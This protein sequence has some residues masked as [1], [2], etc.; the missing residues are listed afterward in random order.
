MRWRA[1][2]HLRDQQAVWVPR[3]HD[4][5]SFVLTVKR[6]ATLLRHVLRRA[7]LC[8]RTR[9]AAT[10]GE[11]EQL[12]AARSSTPHVA[13][14]S[15]RALIV[16]SSEPQCWK[17]SFRESVPKRGCLIPADGFYEWQR[18]AKRKQ[19]FCFEVGDG[20]IL[21]SLACGIAGGAQMGNQWKPAQS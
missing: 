8:E 10:T 21:R 17:P 3:S 18:Q 7:H 12:R 2:G 16:R 5:E 20:G 11:G 1:H 15:A 14:V 9:Q 6:D 19:P 13:A 4:P